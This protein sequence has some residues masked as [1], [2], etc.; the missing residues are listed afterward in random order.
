MAV[1]V[2]YPDNTTRVVQRADAALQRD[3]FVTIGRW[4]SSRRNVEELEN[5][6]LSAVVAVEVTDRRGVVTQIVSGLAKSSDRQ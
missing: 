2:F 5:L 1:K 4:D 3:G 6:P